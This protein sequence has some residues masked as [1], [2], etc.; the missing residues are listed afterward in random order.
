MSKLPLEK[1]D[2]LAAIIEM[3]WDMMQRVNTA[4]PSLCQQRPDT[5]KN[6]RWMSH[7]VL[8]EE[9]LASYLGDLR[10]A[11][12]DGRNFITEKY[13]RMDDLIPPLSEHPAIGDILRTESA[14]MEEL[15]RR[16]PRLFPGRLES[17]QRYARA[18]LETLSDRTLA[19][20]LQDL[21]RAAAA[22]RNL[23]EERYRNLFRKIGL[24]TLE[25]EEAK[26]HGAD[27]S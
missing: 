2:L 27:P 18:E 10:Q 14:W 13:A 12:T 3:E 6:M 19:S 11:V 9:T 26:R 20:Y 21:A 8:S 16:F 4:S 23:V 5:F 15:S 24:G 25:D 17:F 7:S 22:G 1:Q